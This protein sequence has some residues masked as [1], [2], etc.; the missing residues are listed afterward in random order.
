MVIQDKEKKEKKEKAKKLKEISKYVPI[1]RIDPINRLMLYFP[2]KHI[3]ALKISLV[4]L[5]ILVPVLLFLIIYQ[6]IKKNYNL[7]PLIIIILFFNLVLIISFKLGIL[8]SFIVS[9]CMYIWW[10]FWGLVIGWTKPSFFSTF[11]KYARLI[12]LII[13]LICIIFF[14]KAK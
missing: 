6:I 9:I 4:L 3:K 1:K 11:V 8:M 10:F 5:F 2:T 14:Y 13:N 7:V 12:I